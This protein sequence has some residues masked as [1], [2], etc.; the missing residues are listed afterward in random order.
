MRNSNRP[1]T[2]CVG[3]ACLALASLF[4]TAR[5]ASAA[6]PFPLPYYVVAKDTPYTA[7]KK[8]TAQVYGD[9]AVGYPASGLKNLLVDITTPTKLAGVPKAAVLFIHGGGF[10]SGSR[11]DMAYES[12]TFTRMGLITFTIDYR[13]TPDS[14]QVQPPKYG[15][16]GGMFAAMTAGNVDGKAAI[17]WIHAKA[18]SL[19]VDTNNIFVFGCSAGSIIALADGVSPDTQYVKDSTKSVVRPENHPGASQR[20]RGIVSWCGTLYGSDLN[21]LDIHDPP[22]FIYHGTADSTVNYNLVKQMVAKLDTVGLEY[23]FHPVTDSGH[24]PLQGSPDGT[25]LVTS[26]SWVL[27]HIVA[28]GGAS[29]EPVRARRLSLHRV[30]GNLAISLPADLVGQPVSAMFWSVDGSRQAALVSEAS[31][32]ASNLVFRLPD[33]RNGVGLV[34]VRIGSSES[35]L[36]LPPR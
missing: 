15:P 1:K 35:W 19:G 21:S 13:M 31:G 12:T 11:K 18:D 10:S 3:L 20:L 16:S 36:R 22:I 27:R 34:R 9:G 23:E 28:P 32:D 17:R 2:G 6:L 8:D 24:C 29:V 5:S 25:L 33:A 14:P 30:G 7:V 26:R 4:A